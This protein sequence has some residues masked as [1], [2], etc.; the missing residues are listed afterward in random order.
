M[1]TSTCKRNNIQRVHHSPGELLASDVTAVVYRH[2]LYRICSIEILFHPNTPVYEINEYMYKRIFFDSIDILD[3]YGNYKII[4]ALVSKKCI[5][6]ILYSCL[7]NLD[8]NIFKITS[9]SHS[10]I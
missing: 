7:C 4:A 6:Y 2:D 10:Q 9:F 5:K 8:F 3:K 1:H